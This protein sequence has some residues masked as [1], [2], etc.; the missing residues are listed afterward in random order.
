MPILNKAQLLHG[1]LLSL[2]P[3]PF[4]YQCFIKIPFPIRQNAQKINPSKQT[5]NWANV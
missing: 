4:F 1:A 3:L 5:V 2:G